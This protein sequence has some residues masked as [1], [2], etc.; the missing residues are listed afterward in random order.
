MG[1]ICILEVVSKSQDS[2]Y[3]T[4]LVLV[5]GEKDC[6]FVYGGEPL[7]KEKISR[8]AHEYLPNYGLV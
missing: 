3:V 8:I 1:V 2:L 5:P 7:T 6:E 4:A